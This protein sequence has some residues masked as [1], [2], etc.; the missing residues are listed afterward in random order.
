MQIRTLHTLSLVSSVAIILCGNAVAD[1]FHLKDGRSLEGSIL[2]VLEDSYIL[3]VTVRPG[4]K[5]EMTLAKEDLVRIERVLQEHT[6]FAVLESMLPIPDLLQAEDYH[7]RVT[8]IQTFIAKYPHS[9][10]IEQAE[11]ILQ[12][13]LAEQEIIEAGGLKLN[14]EMMPPAKRLENQYYIDAKIAE[15]EIRR[16]SQSPNRINSLRAFQ[17]FEA[18]FMG[19]EAWH[20]L[21]PLMRQL[22]GAHKA[23]AQELLAGYEDRIARRESGLSRMGVEERQATQRAIAERDISLAQRHEQEREIKGYWV[24]INPDYKPALEETIRFADQE[25][26]RLSTAASQ[27]LRQPTPSQVWRNAVTA[28][29]AGEANSIRS[30]LQAARSARM[31]QR[32]LDE[33]QHIADEASR[34]AEEAKQLAEEAKKLAEEAAKL[35]EETQTPAE[36]K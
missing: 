23:N 11:E 2:T 24:S 28:I 33:L 32:Y 5:E 1:I 34:Q 19:S 15:A 9:L 25:M 21:L 7:K 22:V 26:R 6:E 35:A 30:A 17:S 27:P 29:Q 36:E 3:E 8:L 4:I 31:P 10:M 13:H 18:D 20:S 14:G 12:A 16:L